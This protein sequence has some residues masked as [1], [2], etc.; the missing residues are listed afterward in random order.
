MEIELESIW[1]IVRRDAEIV[2]RL[3]RAY[4]NEAY[5]GPKEGALREIIGHA[6]VKEIRHDEDLL[7]LVY[8]LVQ[9]LPAE[10]IA[11]I[12]KEAIE[13]EDE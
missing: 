7:N 12:A 9:E 3:D 1:N 8:G 6:F 4:H 10:D 5:R 2:E 11:K 13:P